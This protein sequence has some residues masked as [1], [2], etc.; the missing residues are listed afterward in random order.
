MSSLTGQE[1]SGSRIK[2]AGTCSSFLL[3]WCHNGCDGVSNQQHHHC[4][5]R[6]RSKK[7]SK[8]R[9]T[10]LCAGNSPMTGEFPARRASNTENISIRWRHHVLQIS[11]HLDCSDSSPTDTLQITNPNLFSLNRVYW[12]KKIHALVGRPDFKTLRLRQNGRH[13]ADDIF[14]CISFNENVES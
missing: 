6:R 9:V 3:E 7:T 1:F 2:L 4:L 5:F 12:K 14:K 11:W 10:G 13:F 8:L